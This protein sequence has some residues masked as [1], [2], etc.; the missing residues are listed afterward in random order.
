MSER[1]LTALFLVAITA[2]AGAFAVETPAATSVGAAAALPADPAVTFGRLD[3]GVRY[4]LMP[5]QQPRDKASIRLL[6]TSG[7][8][9]ENDPQRGLAHFLEHMAFNGTTHYPPGTLVTQLQSLGM[10]FG[11]DT[12][13]HT[14]FDETV[15][16]LDLPD[17]KA[18]TVAIG[19]TVMADYAGGMLLIPAEVERERGIILAE[20]RDRDSPSLRTWRALYRAMYPG[21]RTAERFP[22]G[23]RET[24]TAAD[25]PL[26]KAFY[27][28]W[29]RPER[30]AVVVVGAID[31]AAVAGQVRSAFAG[32]PVRKPVPDPGN[33]T[34]AARELTVAYHREKEDE[35]TTVSLMQLIPRRLPPDS[36]EERRQDLLRDLADTILG[37]RF[38]KL[39]ASHPDGALIEAGSE[40][41]QWLDVFHTGIQA[42]SRPGRSLEALAI[43]EQELRRFLEHGP[44]A[45]ELRIAAAETTA[46]LDEAVAKAANRTNAT[47]ANA[48]C[49]TIK[50]SRAVLSPEQ[51]RALLAPMLAAS[52]PAQVLATARAGWATG[53]RVVTITGADD[54]GADA[55]PRIREAY[56]ASGRI[57]VA[58]PAEETVA[59]W[60]Y[61]KRPQGAWAPMAVAAP[62]GVHQELVDQV[63]VVVRHTTFKPNE[64]LV[65]VRLT[66]PVETRPAG[67]SELVERAYLAGGLGRHSAEELTEVLAGSSVRLGPPRFDDDGVVFAASC[68]PKE[69]ELCAQELM[70]YLTDA[71]WRAEA[72]TRAKSAW[73]DELVAADSNLDAQLARRFQALAVHD[74]PQRRQATRE[75]AEA[76]T[77]AAV[78][79]W[80]QRLVAE[81]PLQITVVGDI[82]EAAA[83]ALLRPYAGALGSGRAA[84]KPLAAP[85]AVPLAATQPIPAGVHTFTVPGQVRR[86]LIRV[87]WPTEDYYDIGRTR[88]LGVLAQVI[89]E[90]MRVKIR[91]ELGDAYSPFAYR[92]ASE[93]YAGYGFVLAQVGVLP[94]KAEEARTA[95]LAIAADLAAN[96]VDAE[97]FTRVMAPVLKSIAVQRQQNQYWMNSVLA[98]VASQPFR[99]L[100]AESM[101]SD[102]AGMT[103]ADVS[104]LAKRYLGNERA[105]QVIAVCEGV[106]AAVK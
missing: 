80:F 13:A 55:E 81:A 60:A 68:L 44:T 74:A 45:G 20:M 66:I 77:F 97:L 10:S 4:A 76:V 30:M 32:I 50:L 33:G 16:K 22:I 43:V 91:E 69:L 62:A 52:T 63:A 73:R 84:L 18:E 87:A 83:L 59:A 17:A 11:A 94:E 7:S 93:A 79:P 100:W 28:D 3:N 39:V 72:E 104:A 67:W 57:A 86:A 34:L 54:L 6:I 56:L 35:G 70:A 102:Y 42:K 89:D 61:G 19:L 5:N 24:V 90:R 8:L 82:D 36:A 85:T 95:L 49:H 1:R 23:E 103:A 31:P 14:S 40:T 78:R 15:Y 88:R 64:V 26:L 46:H 106:P 99:A 58:A 53:N 9:L 2:W 25:A 41:F 38:R 27:D 101:E 98:R 12:N 21:Q 47:L 65:L 48:F 75:E 29:Y 92:Y 37:Q 71:G 51:E 105:L 96:G